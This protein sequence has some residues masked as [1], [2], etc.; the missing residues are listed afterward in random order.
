MMT[1]LEKMGAVI[2]ARVRAAGA[3][4]DYDGKEIARAALEAIREPSDTMLKDCAWDRADGM[5]GPSIE[6]AEWQS[7]IDAIL[8]ERTG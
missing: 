8:N 6:V 2:E 4:Y 3:I 1:M 7:G 5:N